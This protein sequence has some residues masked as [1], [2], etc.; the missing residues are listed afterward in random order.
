MLVF[1]VF[2][3]FSGHFIT[4]EWKEYETSKFGAKM[5]ENGVKYE[6]STFK[7]VCYTLFAIV[8]FTICYSEM[9]LW[10]E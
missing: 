9:S 1:V 5:N 7:T 8:A 2:M 3:T 4:M 6:M 10:K